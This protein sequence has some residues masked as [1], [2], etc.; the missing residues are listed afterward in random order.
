MPHKS[1][2]QSGTPFSMH[3]SGWPILRK[4]RKPSGEQPQFANWKMAIE[5][6]GKTH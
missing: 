2:P 4:V 6:V 5:I 3:G 1:R